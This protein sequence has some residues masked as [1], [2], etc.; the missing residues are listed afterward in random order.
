MNS[1]YTITSLNERGYHISITDFIAAIDLG[2]VLERMT[3]DK[4]D[5]SHIMS[6]PPAYISEI[7]KD[8]HKD[9]V[10]DMIYTSFY[11]KAELEHWLKPDVS[12]ADYKEL[13]DL[14]WDP[15]VAAQL[16][17]VLKTEAGKTVGCSLCFDVFDEPEVPITS[18][19]IIVFEYLETLEGPVKE[20]ILPQGKG[21]TLHS[22]MMGTK[23]DLSTKENVIIMQTMEEEVLKIAM[24]RG[25]EGIFTTNTSPLTQQLAADVYGYQCIHDAQPNLYV[26]PDG[27]KPFGLAPDSQ[28]AMVQWKKI[29]S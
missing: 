24:D 17:F 2:E 21:K 26:A 1:I 13:I 4:K 5:Q 7:L 14:L 27:T 3:Q 11:N 19:L 16:S 15:L 20:K 9:D 25:F 18:K 12:E 8:E 28:R 10:F 22:F 29:K 23:E 6:H